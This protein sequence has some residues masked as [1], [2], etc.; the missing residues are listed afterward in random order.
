MNESPWERG[1]LTVTDLHLGDL[2][3]GEA[4][5]VV[6]LVH[7]AVSL[8]IQRQIGLIFNGDTIDFY[9]YATD[10][11]RLDDTSIL[12]SELPRMVEANLPI[13]FTKGNHDPQLSVEELA[14]FTLLDESDFTADHEFFM[15][16]PEVL[17]SH[18]HKIELLNLTRLS[19]RFHKILSQDFGDDWQDQLPSERQQKRLL[20]LLTGDMELHRESERIDTWY[21]ETIDHPEA[22]KWYPKSAHHLVMA[23]QS[24]RGACSSGLG[25]A[26]TAL[27]PERHAKLR[28]FLQWIASHLRLNLPHRAMRF[29]KSLNIPI[30]VCGHNH[31]P[32]LEVE[33][34]RNKHGE[35][36]HLYANAGSAYQTGQRNTA[37]LIERVESSTTVSLL[38]HQPYGTEKF[39]VLD[40]AMYNRETEAISL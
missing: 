23:F 6:S 24:L 22:R 34:L 35:S 16:H 11:K 13:A 18:G 2:E 39:T 36:T 19:A 30:V 20:E 38:E 3:N 31:V 37:V 4:G 33:T 27:D 1:S 7:D 32:Q 15:P 9:S 21:Q 40:Q 14:K 26:C 10:E 17:V 29:A 5:A 28:G 25:R 12:R 8:A